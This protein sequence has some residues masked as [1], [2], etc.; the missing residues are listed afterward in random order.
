LP[1]ANDAADVIDAWRRREPVFARVALLCPALARL[2]D[3][4]RVI[5]LRNSGHTIAKLLLPCLGTPVLRVVNHTHR[6]Y[7]ELQRDFLAASGAD[8]LSLRG[9]EGE[10]VADPRRTP[11]FEIWLGGVVRPELSSSA[12]DG[13]LTELPLL[14]RQHDAA[15]TALYIQSVVS[16]ERPAPPSLLRQVECLS[17]ALSSFAAPALPAGRL[18]SP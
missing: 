6:D 17:A 1:V 7:A 5:G 15:T 11:K 2:L 16:G 4:R 8:A 9:T 14:P 3:V 10:P 18:A 13:V 12:P